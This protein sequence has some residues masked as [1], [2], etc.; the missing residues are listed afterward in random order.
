M[1][2]FASSSLD[3]IERIFSSTGLLSRSIQEYEMR[4]EQKEMSLKVMEAYEGDLVLLVEAA[5]GIGKSWAY[6][7]PALL[8]AAA[9]KGF[10]VISTN[11]IALQ[12]QL[13]KKD[14]PFL[15]DI[16]KLDLQATLVKGMSNY[17][18][19]RKY[20]EALLEKSL[21]TPQEKSDMDKL[22]LFAET[23]REGSFSEMNS[24]LSPGMW[25]KVS[26]E[27]SACTHVECPHFK[28]CFFF[29]ARKA[30]ED[31]QILIVNHHLL[32]AEMAM[33]L[34]P[35]FQE[36]KS[37]L[38]KFS[39]IVVDEAH[40][41]EEIALES[42]SVKIDRLDLVRYL[43]RIYSDHQPQKSRLGLLKSD[44]ASKGVNCS[45]TLAMAIDVDIP[46]QKRIALAT[47]EQF[48]LSVEEFCEQEL[49][50]ESS[51]EMREKRW[52]FSDE[53]TAI[54]RWQEEV[55]GL[56]TFVQEE[57]KKLFSSLELLKQE[58]GRGLSDTNKDLFSLHF[59]AL[60]MITGVLIQRLSQ[61][62]HF[63]VA[64]SDEKRVRWVEI[65]SPLAMKNIILVD[66]KLN[67]SEYL[68]KYLFLAK[69]TAVLCSAT[70]TSNQNFSFLKQQI[71]ISGK[72]FAER[73]SEKTYDS[74][75]D[76]Q[77]NALFL[78]PS[79]ISYPHEYG[80]IEEAV[81]MIKEILKVSH[82]GCFILFTSYDMLQKCYD[83]IVKAPDRLPFH[84]LRQGEAA[85]Q[86]LIEKFK[87][88]K[89]SV[90]FA[91]SS[92]W[93][94][95]DIAGNALRCVILT[96]LPF[97]VPSEPLFQAMS[98]M[99]TKEGKDPFSE[100]SLPQACLKF[101]QG[102]GRLIRTKEDRGCVVCLDK[103]IMTKPYGKAFL[104]SLPNCPVVYK[105][106][107]ELFK[108]MQEFYQGFGA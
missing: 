100:Y 25:E 78:V 89:D 7:V 79:D 14:I 83:K 74:P 68:K 105:K 87:Q 66:A 108:S 34:R 71:G 57:W 43:G 50:S 107:V 18:C 21:F 35:D 96:K 53:K 90:L 61:L 26:A 30:L 16:L 86:T 15:L 9:R 91:T 81:S 6:L 3:C 8:W 42:F 52:R 12:E 39:K 47:L 41:L 17:F 46:A 93:E 59:T 24:P 32:V 99:Y 95:I 20:E 67:V 11:T 85:K 48:F 82:G 65:S 73:V 56:F 72:E 4:Q 75:F 64:P 33:R 102:F 88:K 80:F 63:V 5:T 104:K 84:Y 94:G 19:F 58:I 101:K 22:Q 103:R 60:D 44:L 69:D 106:R 31:S 62:E 97:R 38:P 49:I 10:T 76:F 29:K 2:E 13:I 28:E 77:K 40:H 1:L 54:S 23:C 36:E 98:E 55:K 92:F 27:R 45:S 51:L 37:I 70:L